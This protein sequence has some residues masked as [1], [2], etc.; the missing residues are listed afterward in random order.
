MKSKSYLT[1]R[2]I[3]NIFVPPT[4]TLISFIILGVAF[5]ATP[6]MKISV[7]FSG[8]FFGLLIPIIFFLLL[9]K[10]GKIADVDATIKEERGGPFLFGV[11]LCTLAMLL[12]IYLDANI[13]SILL[14]GTYAVN[15]LLLILIN[16]FWKISAHAIGVSLP[17]GAMTFIW[18]SRG[19][20]LL[21]LLIA[22]GWSRLRLGVHDIYQVTAGSLFGF[23]L[24]YLQ[25]YFLINY[26]L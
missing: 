25:Y 13:N 6:V 24:T 1:A 16:K 22:V 19:L 20:L 2:I 7:A 17:M 4:I 9:M 11:L 23:C 3:S 14:W 15:T 8:L 12:L 10:R 18:G 5:E 21:P 26:V